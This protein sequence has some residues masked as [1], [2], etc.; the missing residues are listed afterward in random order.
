MVESVGTAAVTG[1]LSTLGPPSAQVSGLNTFPLVEN[2][3]RG[4]VVI[5]GLVERD[6]VETT[7]VGLT[8]ESTVTTGEPHISLV[9]VTSPLAGLVR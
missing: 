1:D 4:A 9:T 7:G 5:T 3:G 8:G 2:S 6:S